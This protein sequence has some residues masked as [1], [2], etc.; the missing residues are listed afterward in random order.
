M[1]HDFVYFDEE[2]KIT[3]MCDIY[4]SPE[5]KG[6]LD[7]YGLKNEPDY[8]EECYIE[9]MSMITDHHNRDISPMID[10]GIKDYIV[11]QFLEE[12]KSENF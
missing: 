1:N 10:E 9:K 2:T 8:P 11:Q 3:F 4:Y 7:G 5:E 12:F 6:S